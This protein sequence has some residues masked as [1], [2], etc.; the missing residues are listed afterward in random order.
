MRLV[1]QREPTIDDTTLGSLYLD[2]HRFCDTLE[3]AI[4][5]L[6]GVSVE[7]WKIRGSTA[8]PAGTYPLTLSLSN[9][10]K[11][12]LPEV[13][14]VPGFTGIR[15]HPGNTIHDTE[16]CLL[17]GMGRNGRTVTSSKVAFEKLLAAIIADEGPH[18]IEYRNP[19]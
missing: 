16:G 8:I 17:V 11:R 18:T 3:D 15:L 5:E 12:L 7:H 9:R 10:F 4:R 19:L 14:E 13:L 1:V 2:G 6:V